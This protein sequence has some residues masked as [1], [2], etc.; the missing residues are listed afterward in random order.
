M[1][2]NTDPVTS[3]KSTFTNSSA[4]LSFLKKLE[5]FKNNLTLNF[6]F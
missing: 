1:I 3:V 2:S 5:N 4:G 6:I